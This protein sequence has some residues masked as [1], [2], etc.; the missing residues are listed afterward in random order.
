MYYNDIID[1]AIVYLE[2]NYPNRTDDYDRCR[3][4]LKYICQAID[5]DMENDTT[6]FIIRVANQFWQFG[7]RQIKSYDAEIAVY[8]FMKTEYAVHV[9]ASQMPKVTRSIDKLIDIVENGI[10]TTSTWHN[11]VHGSKN[12]EHCQRNWLRDYSVPKTDIDAMVHVAT[13]MPSK[14]NLDYFKLIVST[15]AQLNRFVYENSITSDGTPVNRNAQTDANI[16][17]IYVEQSNFLTNTIAREENYYHQRTLSIGISSGALTLAANQMGYRSGFCQ[18]YLKPEIKAKLIEYGV[19]IEEGEDVELLVG[20]GKPNADVKWSKIL[21][22]QD[23]IIND[24]GSLNKEVYVAY[25]NP[26]I[27]PPIT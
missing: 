9:V 17:F 23:Q 7:D 22:D 26:G 4:D 18:C 12:A 10:D 24:A 11:I 27:L 13:N 1:A 2:T 16:L 19:S 3:R 14:Q 5:S 25:V 20:V 15:D 8:N 21:N 6:D